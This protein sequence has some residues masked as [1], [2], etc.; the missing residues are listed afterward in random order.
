MPQFSTLWIIGLEFMAYESAQQ[1][2]DDG[3]VEKAVHIHWFSICFVQPLQETIRFLQYAVFRQL[4][5]FVH[6]S[7]SFQDEASLFTS[8]WAIAETKAF[9][10][11]TSIGYTLMSNCSRFHQTLIGI[12]RGLGFLNRPHHD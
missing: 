11:V 1:W 8:M 6:V 7:K 2:V 4:G 12:G 3:A 9:M 10:K 5:W